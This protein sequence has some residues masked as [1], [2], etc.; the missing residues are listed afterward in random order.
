MVESLAGTVRQG[1]PLAGETF[2]DAHAHLGVFKDYYVPDEDATGMVAYMDRYGMGQA[3]IF[4]F[5]GVASDFVYG[6]DLVVAAVRARPDRLLGYTVLSPNYPEECIPE[7]ERTA[8]LGLRGIKLIAYYQ[9]HREDTPRLFPVYE[10]AQARRKIILSHTWGTPEFLAGLARQY[11]DVSF[12]IGHMDFNYAETVRRY[13]NVFTTTTFVPWPGAIAR[14]V[15]AFGAD[16]ILF[17]SDFPD[18]DTSLNL[19]PLLTAR[20]SDADKR[21]ILGGNM[22]RI[23][24]EH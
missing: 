10:W 21:K 18:L 8:N 13:D 12:H 11:P 1:R 20:I 22:Q 7:L 9:G 17:G 6:N 5:A 23:L 3:C 4:A 15:D 19:G 24:A 16:K 2:I 14:A